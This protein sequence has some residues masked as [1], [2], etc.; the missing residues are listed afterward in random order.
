MINRCYEK[1][2]MEAAMKKGKMRLIPK[3]A[4]KTLDGRF[5][6]NK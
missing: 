5:K 6:R 1:G 4:T 2:R 3:S